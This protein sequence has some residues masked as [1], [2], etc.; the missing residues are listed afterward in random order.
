MPRAL[1]RRALKWIVLWLLAFSSPQQMIFAQGSA[2]DLAGVKAVSYAPEACEALA[3]TRHA[4]FRAGQE[5]IAAHCA[6][7]NAGRCG[8]NTGCLVSLNTIQSPE[9]VSLDLLLESRGE[10]FAE[11]RVELRVSFPS[12]KGRTARAKCI[13]P[14][15]TAEGQAYLQALD[16]RLSQWAEE[17]P[18]LM[19]CP[20]WRTLGE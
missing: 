15:Q 14:D 20:P 3:S 18:E 5:E 12:A 16:R 11:T 10:P 1:G 4:L 19:F 6:S 17:H 7:T 8:W 13:P 2:A 9:T